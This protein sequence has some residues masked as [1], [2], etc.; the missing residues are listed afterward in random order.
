MPNRS[1]LERRYWYYSTHSLEDKGVHTSTKGIC[2][3]G[4][5][6]V[7]LEFELTYY[8]SAAQRLN[9]YTTFLN[10]IDRVIGRAGH[11]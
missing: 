2:P 3:K 10:N 8:D 5:V 11:E 9:H 1:F 6:I 4:N 7:R